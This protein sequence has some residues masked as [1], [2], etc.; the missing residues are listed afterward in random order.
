MAQ[1][2]LALEA[3][4][5]FGRDRKLIDTY[6]AHLDS[7]DMFTPIYGLGNTPNGRYLQATAFD[8]DR[9]VVVIFGGASSNPRM[10]TMSLNQ[11]TWEWSPATG[12]WTNRTGAGPK[13]DA[14]SGAAF[15]YDSDRRLVLGGRR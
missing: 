4:A 9:N 10:P 5:R 11:E 3:N 2:K 15:A 1:T 13:P 6:L 8:E 12:K 7:K 14:R